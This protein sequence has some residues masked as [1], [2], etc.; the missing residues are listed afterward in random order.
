MRRAATQIFFFNSSGSNISQRAFFLKLSVTGYIYF[1]QFFMAIHVLVDHRDCGLLSRTK[2]EFLNLSLTVSGMFV[3]ARS[4]YCFFAS[5]VR[6]RSSLYRIVGR[7]VYIYML[8][9]HT[10]HIHCIH[11]CN[12]YC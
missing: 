10:C 8:H 3:K 5:K 12:I 6:I 7:T 11:G 9:T 4:R 1:S 2:V